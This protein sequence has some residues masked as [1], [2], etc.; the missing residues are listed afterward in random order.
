MALEKDVKKRIPNAPSLLIEFEKWRAGYLT[1]NPN[2][3]DAHF[4]DLPSSP[5]KPSELELM[6]TQAE[7]LARFPGKLH[8]AAEILKSV[9][10]RDPSLVEKYS[11][12]LKLWQKGLA[13]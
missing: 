4:V 12:K 5:K 8:L 13:G 11:R 9:I 7:A 1:P 2:I 6:A 3:V 10:S